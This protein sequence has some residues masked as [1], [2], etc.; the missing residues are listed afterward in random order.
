MIRSAI[1][2]H[3]AM[4]VLS[5]LLLHGTALSQIWTPAPQVGRTTVSALLAHEGVLYAGAWDHIYRS[6]DSGKSWDPPR[7][8]PPLGAEPDVSSFA[9][10]DAAV[11][12]GTML[13][14][15]YRSTNHG[16]TW[17]RFNEG[18]SGNAL[19][20]AHLAVLGDSIYAGT[21]GAGVYV[22]DVRGTTPWEP[23][24]DGLGWYTV[25]SLTEF[26]G[27]I[28][29][30]ISEF[31]FHRTPTTVWASVPWDASGSQRAAID[32][33]VHRGRLY[34]G[35][36][37]G[38]MRWD[39]HASMWAQLDLSPAP[40]RH[41]CN[42]ASIGDSLFAVL[43]LSLG[44]HQL[45]LSGDGGEH[46][47]SIEQTQGEVHA[48][49]EFAGTLWSAR[50][51]GLWSRPLENTS[52]VA[53]P[54]EAAAIRLDPP[55]PQPA[56]ASASLLLHL[57]REQQVTIRVHD[58][59]GR[60]VRTIEAD[61]EYSPGTHRVSADLSRLAPGWYVVRIDTPS[62]VWLRPLLHY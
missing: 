42:F 46:W 59:L 15:I 54:S 9:A 37:R 3:T 26:D 20:V 50:T 24:N 43:Q 28:C 49:I 39:G 44:W 27:R 45:V 16:S 29:A 8:F 41:G 38:I 23:F 61:R 48:L 21:D 57:A 35:V 62:G 31:F 7:D 60:A 13:D 5:F 18:L 52:G 30:Q 47:Q 14:G 6:L 53:R 1:H 22:R 33:F 51:D 58:A 19:R 32:L 10:A 12:A 2:R 40:N 36:P 11:F 34:A 55:W 4:L 25:N 56:S 17:T